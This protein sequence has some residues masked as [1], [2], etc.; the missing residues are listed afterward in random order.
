MILFMK[1]SKKPLMIPVKINLG[2]NV[3]MNPRSEYEE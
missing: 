1:P 3:D 2:I